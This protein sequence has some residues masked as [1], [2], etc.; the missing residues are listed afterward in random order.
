MVCSSSL[1]AESLLLR[2]PFSMVQPRGSFWSLLAGKIK[3]YLI[4]LPILRLCQA[5]DILVMLRTPYFSDAIRDFAPIL[6]V[7]HFC[8]SFSRRFK[9]DCTVDRTIQ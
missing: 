8:I 2:I 3:I 1:Q 5:A 4:F 7:Q 6:T 9:S